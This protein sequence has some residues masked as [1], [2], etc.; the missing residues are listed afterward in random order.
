MNVYKDQK[1]AF[2]EERYFYRYRV[3]QKLHIFSIHMSL[4]LVKIK[5]FGY[6][7]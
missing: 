3:C 5:L 6:Q 4:Q 2:F 7:K 1:T